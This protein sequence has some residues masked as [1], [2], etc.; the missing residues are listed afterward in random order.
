MKTQRELIEIYTKR[1]RE[2]NGTFEDIF[3]ANFSQKENVFLEFDEGDKKR[4]LTFGEVERMVLSLAYSLEEILEG[5]KDTYLAL[6]MDNSYQWIV[7]FWAIL[8]SGNKPYLVNLRHPKEL[9]SSI[10][11]TLDIEFSLDL[12]KPNSYG[13]N[14]INVNFYLDKEVPE[15]HKYIWGNE[16][17]LS[18]SATTMQEK[19]CIYSGKEILA[20]LS[21]TERI[22]RET[23]VVRKTYGG[24]IKLLA[25][26]PFYHI[27]GLIATYFWFTYFGYEIVL[28]KDY[29]PETILRTIR[30]YGVTHLFAVP[31]FWHTIE[32]TIKS[33]VA[34]KGEKTQ[35]K[36][37]KGIEIA[38]KLPSKLS[39]FFAKRAFKEVRNALFGD[40]IQF[41]ISG[42]SYLRKDAQKL[43]NSLGY[44]LFNGY[45]SSEIGITSCDFS[46]SLKV[47]NTNSV[48]KPFSS[49]SYKIEDGV[50]HV[51]GNSTC[52]AIIVNGVRTETGSD[53]NT[54]DLAEVDA[55]GNYHILGRQSDLIVPEGGENINPDSLE[56]CFDLTHFNV[57]N[58]AILGLGENKD[59]T[60]MVIQIGKESSKDE[61]E[62]LQKYVYGVNDSLPST[63]KVVSF[64]LTFDPLQSEGA[65]KVSRTYLYRKIEEKKVH[66]FH[67][68][69]YNEAKKEFEEGSIEDTLIGLFAKNLGLSKE[70]VTPTSHFGYDLH[71]G[72]LEYYSLMLEINETF[73]LDLDYDPEHPLFTVEDFAKEI[74]NRRGE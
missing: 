47:R 54:L 41:C 10:I 46:K 67:F 16:I 1:I 34:K 52:K 30:R 40:S 37:Y 71:G 19:I 31:L 2:G 25:F 57:S 59:Q 38:A 72:S 61:V 14:S 20:Q 29:A 70:K 42:G 3:D 33:E 36:F 50:L 6:N 74:R 11:K 65:I 48:G 7:S 9:T 23:R 18:T 68:D 45:G 49:V 28:L 22:L 32:K 66:L 26:L 56:L 73:H 8:M 53:F 43:I 15:G 17:A 44:P 27:F 62:K 35:K 4:S 39:F 21:N 5:R 58:M 51:K 63:S 60:T 24:T 69:G 64:Y 55:R 12:D 13:V